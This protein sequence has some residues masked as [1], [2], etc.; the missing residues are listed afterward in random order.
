M[1][2]KAPTPVHAESVSN[3]STTTSD[4]QLTIQYASAYT[5]ST[6]S[7]KKWMEQAILEARKATPKPT[8]F[9]VGAVLVVYPIE[10]DVLQ[11]GDASAISTGYTGELEGNTHAEENCLQKL[12]DAGGVTEW[13]GGSIDESIGALQRAA[14]F[15]STLVNGQSETSVDAWH[16]VLYTTMEPC[17]YRLSKN[18]SCVDR[19]L[20]AAKRPPDQDSKPAIHEVVVGVEE[21]NDFVQGNRGRHLLEAEGMQF[22]KVDGF[23]EEILYVSRLGHP[24]TDGQKKVDPAVEKARGSDMNEAGTLNAEQRISAS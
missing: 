5:I 20:N 10:G 24:K 9:C 4:K 11:E 22:T 2:T 8:N 12:A 13:L 17:T 14:S 21:P 23:E 15:S 6:A 16:V 3:Q 1:T 7:H 18:T 19:I